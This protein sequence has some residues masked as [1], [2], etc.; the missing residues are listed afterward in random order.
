MFGIDPE[1]LLYFA[2]ALVA[3]LTVHESAHA[4]VASWLGDPTGRKLGRVSLNPLVH[5]DPTGTLMIL[6]A[7]L[8]GI[9]FG[10]AKPVPV[11]PLNLR[12]GPKTGMAIVAGAGPASNLLL[13]ALLAGLLQFGGDFGLWT[14]GDLWLRLLLVYAAYVNVSLAVFNLLPLA[15]L[16]GFSVLLGLLPNRTAYSLAR[17]E[18]YG[19]AIL[20][21]LVFFGG[22]V[23]GSYMAFFGHPILRALGLIA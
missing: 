22:G 7:S 6:V 4:L 11:N 14:G 20:L 10:W 19:P 1:R 18:Q 8:A 12:T 16:D 2:V 15:P 21:L 9:G 5:L 23:L 13:A 17:L 3:G